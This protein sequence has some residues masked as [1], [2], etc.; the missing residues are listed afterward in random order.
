MKW[1]IGLL[2]AMGMLSALNGCQIVTVP[3]ATAYDVTQTVAVGGSAQ[4]HLVYSKKELIELNEEMEAAGVPVTLADTYEHG[5]LMRFPESLKNGRT[6]H[7]A[8]GIETTNT[9]FHRILAAKNVP[10][11]GSYLVTMIETAQVEG[12]TLFAIVHRP[13]NAIRV[14]KKLDPSILLTIKPTEP[15]YYIPYRQEADGRRLDTVYDWAAVPNDCFV[16]QEQQAL[17]L[18]LM[19]NKV[20]KQ[21][22]APNYWK[23]EEKWLAGDHMTVVLEQDDAVCGKLGLEKGTTIRRTDP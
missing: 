2:A 1:M 10:D 11:A 16:T 21:E 23:A 9:Y 4:P 17:L 5:Y 19:S 18:T 12:F 3:T 20:I 7:L 8:G 15:E 22:R 13:K 6:S 14:K